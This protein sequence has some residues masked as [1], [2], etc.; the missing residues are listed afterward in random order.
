MD[1][2]RL[3]G[4]AF[5]LAIFAG[6]AVEADE[7]ILVVRQDMHQAGRLMVGASKQ[8]VTTAGEVELSRHRL[9]VAEVDRQLDEFL[10]RHTDD[11][12]ALV[13]RDASGEIVPM[14]VT[15]LRNII[16]AR[17]TRLAD[18]RENHRRWGTYAQSY[19]DVLAA[20]EAANEMTM[21]REVDWLE[22]KRSAAAAANSA[23][24]FISGSGMGLLLGTL[25]IP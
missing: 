19:M 5:M 25:V 17:D 22:K 15:Q 1:M 24:G 9:E 3:I 16:A 8:L 7:K 23:L 11:T 21:E 6:C 20:F 2:K 4:A 14:P 18:V 10:Q 12:G 13:S